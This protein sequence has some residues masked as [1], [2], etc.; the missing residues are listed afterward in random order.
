[1]CR[2][3]LTGVFLT[4]PLLAALACAD[5]GSPDKID[6]TLGDF[7]ADLSGNV[8]NAER[9]PG[10]KATQADIEA[11][12]DIDTMAP[13]A[14]V[15]RTELSYLIGQPGR[16]GGG[17]FCEQDCNCECKCKNSKCKWKSCDDS[18]KCM[19]NCKGKACSKDDDDDG[20]DDG[21]GDGGGDY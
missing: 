10:S 2:S 9:T 19:R 8:N 21:G 5:Y 3:F 14:P 13:D 4:A 7:S 15:K 18:K 17:K 11:Q 1:M 16:G 12:D 20:G 6:D